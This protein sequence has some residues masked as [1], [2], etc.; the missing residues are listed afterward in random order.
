MHSADL[1]VAI[2]RQPN[3]YL[4]DLIQFGPKLLEVP[5]Q[6]VAPG[7][8]CVVGFQQYVQRSLDVVADVLLQ[9][10]HLFL[11]SH[12]I[13]MDEIEPL[14]HGVPDLYT[15][16]RRQAQRRFEVVQPA[17]ILGLVVVKVTLGL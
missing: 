12:D 3:A 7:R 10:A 16:I 6:C 1:R 14:K 11:E 5:C 13:A 2:V 8:V 15:D 9:I 4:L 17:F